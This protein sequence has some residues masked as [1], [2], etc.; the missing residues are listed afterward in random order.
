MKGITSTQ[1][2]DPPARAWGLSQPIFP[3]YQETH[4]GE[5]EARPLCPFQYAKRRRGSDRSDVLVGVA[6]DHKPSVENIWRSFFCEWGRV[7]ACR[8]TASRRMCLEGCR[9]SKGAWCSCSTDKTEHGL[10]LDS[11]TFLKDN[12]SIRRAQTGS[13]ARTA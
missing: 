9:R 5:T 3:L 12:N 7:I 2:P 4:D 8:A 1:D 11:C 10:G 13:I 6:R